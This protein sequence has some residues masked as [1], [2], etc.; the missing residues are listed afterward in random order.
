MT[1]DEMIKKVHEIVFDDRPIKLRDIVDIVGIRMD[2]NKVIL[3]T[4]QSNLTD[5]LLRF[6]IVNETQVH[7]TTPE[8]M[9]QPKQWTFSGELRGYKYRF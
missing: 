2:I 6:V 3:D 1:T 5:A 9:K 8:T 4:Y 7:H